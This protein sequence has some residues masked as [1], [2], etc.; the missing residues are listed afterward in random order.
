MDIALFERLLYEEESPTLDFKREQYRFVKASDDD[1]SELLKD[2]IGFANAWRRSEAYI[3]IG[4]EEVRGGRSNVIGISEADHLHDHNLQQ[5][6]NLL[7]NRPIH[8]HYEAFAVNDKQVGIIRIELQERPIYLKHDYGKLRKE[9]VYVRRGSSTDPTKPASIEEIASMGKA[10]GP[11]CAELAVEFSDTES[12]DEWGTTIDWEAEFCEMPSLADIPDYGSRQSAEAGAPF[13]AT[14]PPDSWPNEDYYRELLLFEFVSRLAKPMRFMVR[15]VG[16]VAADDVQ[17]ELEIP[18]G[19]GVHIVESGEMPRPPKHSRPR[20]F[21]LEP[22]NFKRIRAQ[23]PGDVTI[24]RNDDRYLIA[25]CCGD[26][27][28]GRR[29]WSDVFFVSV[30]ENGRFELP[31]RIY[32]R[33]LPQPKEFILT[34]NA[35]ISQTSMTVEELV[36]LPESKKSSEDSD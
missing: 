1:K 26:L 28:P 35:T 7:T 23:V 14:H 15:N 24:D 19:A 25:M 16:Q 18:V 17:C 10:V 12:D 9:Q 5:F 34:I 6:M 29:V 33:N 11:T 8:F 22:P 31:G 32:A 27:Q 4:V 21:Y 30:N 2:I 13:P 3:I 20:G 36:R